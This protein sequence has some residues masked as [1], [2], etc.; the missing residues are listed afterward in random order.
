MF[1]EATTRLDSVKA[2]KA[3]PEDGICVADLQLPREL[4]EVVLVWC[5]GATSGDND[6]ESTPASV[7]RRVNWLEGTDWTQDTIEVLP[8]VCLWGRE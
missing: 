5:C 6:L 4:D 1:E 3:V 2:D 8:G 7:R